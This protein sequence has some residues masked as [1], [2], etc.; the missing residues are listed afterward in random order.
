MKERKLFLD[1]ITALLYGACIGLVT[2]LIQIGIAAFVAPSILSATIALLSVIVMTI[3][4][5]MVTVKPFR[6]YLRFKSLR[7]DE[8]VQYFG[9]EPIPGELVY[10]IDLEDLLYAHYL[11]EYVEM[12]VDHN[13][14]AMVP[15]EEG[16]W[17]PEW[18]PPEGNKTYIRAIILKTLVGTRIIEECRVLI[19]GRIFVCGTDK[20][21]ILNCALC[22]DNKVVGYCNERMLAAIWH[23]LNDVSLEENELFQDETEKVRFDFEGGILY[24]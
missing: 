13:I 8:I 19:K 18:R 9:H 17:Y 4:A 7:D 23:A 12:G 22:A 21:T 16:Y 6:N 3:F 14:I 24:G 2:L 20:A 15:H 5:G 11:P 1:L 10:R